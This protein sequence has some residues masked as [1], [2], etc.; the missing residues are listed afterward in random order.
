[1]F[2]ALYGRQSEV[3]QLGA[4]IGVDYDVRWFDIAVDDAALVSLAQSFTDLYGQID[5]AI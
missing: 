4:T 1:M 2:D 5:Y 3:E